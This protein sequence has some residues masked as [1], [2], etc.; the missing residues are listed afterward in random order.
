MDDAAQATS[1][2]YLSLERADRI[3]MAR[4]GKRSGG[5]QSLEVA[6]AG[7]NSA[8]EAWQAL[9][10]ELPNWIRTTEEKSEK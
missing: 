1:A 10:K 8:E 7:F 5:Q 9:Q 4:A 3:K 2:E 6:V